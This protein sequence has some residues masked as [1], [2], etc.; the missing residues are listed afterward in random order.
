MSETTEMAVGAE[1]SAKKSRDIAEEPKNTK[2][3]PDEEVEATTKTTKAARG[4]KAAKVADT[5]SVAAE[6][7]TEPEKK[8][9]KN[10]KKSAKETGTTKAEKTKSARARKQA[11][12]VETF[13]AFQEQIA[14]NQKELLDSINETF[15][16]T[17]TTQLKRAD[18]RRRW[19]NFF[20]D[21]IIVFLALGLGYTIH[22]LY[23]L[24]YHIEGSKLV[25]TETSEVEESS[26]TEPVKDDAW[27]LANYSYLLDQ[28][29]T[30]LNADGV[31]AY[32]L[33]SGDHKI[34]D[35]KPEYLLNMAYRQV[36]QDQASAAANGNEE[37]AKT[38][39]TQAKENTVILAADTLKTKFTDLFGDSVK[40]YAGNFTA[41]CLN[42]AYQRGTETFEAKNQTCALNQHREIIEEIERIYQEGEVIYIISRAGIYD[43]DEQSFYNFNDLFKPVA[44]EVK[45][46]DFSKYKNQLNR[47]QYQFNKDGEKFYFSKVTKLD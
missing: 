22:L 46:D 41:G 33:Y 47:Y 4:A 28:I 35:I 13:E 43:K 18:R 19:N 2:P 31:A 30:D 38:E 37:T 25:E 36:S 44:K 11:L 12:D 3:E 15:Q 32:Y 23:N 45:V 39:T 9:R 1:K 40:F 34:S 10:S 8:P 5:A 6:V 29:K 20:R 27:Y 42:F 17:M 21:L 7:D 14:I 26:E 24:G 16:T